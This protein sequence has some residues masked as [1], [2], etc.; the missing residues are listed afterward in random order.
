MNEWVQ[1]A[2]SAGAGLLGATIGLGGNLWVHGRSRKIERQRRCVDRLVVAAAKLDLAYTQY[3]DQI[4]DGVPDK[5]A[6]Q[7]LQVAVRV[8]NQA[9][10][11]LDHAVLRTHALSFATLMRTSYLFLNSEP[12]ELDTDRQVPTAE[13]LTAAHTALASE[14]RKYESKVDG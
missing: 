11:L 1:P 2:I 14:L 4:A 12:D 5:R 3:L 9:A 13:Q 10:E 8:Y 7:S 6:A